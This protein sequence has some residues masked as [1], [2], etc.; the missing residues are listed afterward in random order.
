MAATLIE[1]HCD[2]LPQ[3]FRA[4]D[5]HGDEAMNAL[6]RWEVLGVCDDGLI[7]V[8]QAVGA[9]AALRLVDELEGTARPVGLVVTDVMLEGEDRDGH[10]ITVILAPPQWALTLRSGYRIFQDKTT[11]EIVE[12]LLKDAGIPSDQVVWRLSGTY[13]KRLHC[14]QY[15]ETEWAFAERL[16]ADEGISYWFDAEDDGKPL[17]IFGDATTSHDGLR[18]SRVLPYEDAGNKI[19]YRR[20]L[21]LE[22]VDSMVTTA[23]H[24]RD[25]DVRAPAVL[26][27]GK[28]GEGPLEY[29][30]YPA[31]VLTSDAAEAR[32]KVRLDQLQ[33]L[34]THVLAS[35]DCVRLQPGRVV[36]VEGCADAWMN[37]DHLVVSV[38][39]QVGMGAQNASLGASYHAKVTM[40]PHEP[41]A[42]R[43]GIPG[44]LPKVEG[45]ESAFTTGPPGAEIHVD[46]LGRVKVRFPW[47]RSGITD[48]TSSCWVRCLQMGMGGSML[49]PRVGWEVPVVY[50]DG[51]PDLPFVLGRFYNATAVVPY[52]LPGAAAT[53]TLQSA[54]SPGGGSTN[55]IRMGDGAGKQEMFIHRDARRLAHAHVDDQRI[56]IAHGRRRPGRQRRHRLRDLGRRQPIRDDRRHGEHQG[57]GE[58]Q[59]HLR[60]VHRAHRRALWRSV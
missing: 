2:A 13:L 41:R 39:H 1:L 38:R 23:A 7:D 30:E 19:S 59:P 46:D 40:V 33:R 47:D 56:A 26:I 48:D 28:A 21:E 37:G 5:V 50:I 55:E 18:E 57:D 52:G 45:L 11:K 10:R 53:T 12:E 17:L 14:V 9:R 22:R 54:T 24:V 49:L 34:K 35:S 6:S 3:S 58:P 44:R 16:L 36:K 27:E 43:P 31:C 51:N 32:A 42:F 29:Y 4:I 15:G 60:L 8:D 25:F 20:F